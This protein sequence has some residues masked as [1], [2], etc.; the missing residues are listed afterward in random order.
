MSVVHKFGHLFQDA[1]PEFAFE[2]TEEGIAYSRPASG[3][4]PAFQPLDEGTLVVSPLSDNVHK[5]EILAERVRAI[6]GPATG[7]RRRCAVLIL[8]DF[9]SRVAVLG[10]D[11][12]PANPDEQKSL[13]RFRMKKS[14][15]FIS[16]R[17]WS[18]IIRWLRVPGKKV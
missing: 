4:P 10:F 13:V 14:V 12:F 3:V 15:P 11:S 9:C 8:P 6:T 16:N 1:A 7:R 5:P 18:G 17:P 2:L